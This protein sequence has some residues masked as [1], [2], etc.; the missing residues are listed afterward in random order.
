MFRSILTFLISLGLKKLNKSSTALNLK[1]FFTDT[2][3][4][5]I[6]FYI[7]MQILQVNHDLYFTL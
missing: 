4:L 6:I 5:R 7:K 2:L 3:T 1:Q